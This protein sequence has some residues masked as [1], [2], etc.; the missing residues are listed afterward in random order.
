MRYWL[1][2]RRTIAVFLELS[3][4]G[5]QAYMAVNGGQ[6]IASSIR[7]ML[8]KDLRHNELTCRA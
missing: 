1:S 4:M 6:R 8:T 2:Y 3:R 7:G 5:S